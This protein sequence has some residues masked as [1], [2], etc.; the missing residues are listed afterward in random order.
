M[1]LR[2]LGPLFAP[3][4]APDIQDWTLIEA[5]LKADGRGITVDL[6]EVR[7][8]EI[9]SGRL[10]GSRAIRLPG[11]VDTVDARAVASPS[12]FVLSAA[13]VPAA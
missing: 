5:A 6:A 4:P 12:G 10:A 1:P 2:D 7:V 3:A 9:G 13:M 11:R 8:G